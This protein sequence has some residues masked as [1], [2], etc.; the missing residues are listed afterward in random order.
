MLLRGLEL[1]NPCVAGAMR[2]DVMMIG[3]NSR[4]AEIDGQIG[5]QPI[6]Q[7]VE[8]MAEPRGKQIG[9]PLRGGR[10]QVSKGFIADCGLQNPAG[11]RIDHKQRAMGLD[12]ARNPDGFA[13]ASVFSKI[14]EGGR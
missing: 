5:L 8:D 9:Q 7:I 3:G 6:G 1:D 12:R 4:M 2:V 13:R 10:A 11:R 14:D